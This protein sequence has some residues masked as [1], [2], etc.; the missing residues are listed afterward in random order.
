MKN[1]LLAIALLALPVVASAQPV[2]PLS[3]FPLNREELRDCM[4]RDASLRDRLETLDEERAAND[5]E[6]ELIA[7]VGNRLA[8]ELRSLDSSNPSAVAAYN[9][10]SSAHNRRVDAHNRR[11]AEANMQASMHNGDAYNLTQR[12]ATRTY[13]IRDRDAVMRGEPNR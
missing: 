4:D 10:R 2:R 13:T 7:R 11:V 6:G 8:D 9:A 5:R 1:K 12:C 3:E